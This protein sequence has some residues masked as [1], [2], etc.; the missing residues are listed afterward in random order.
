MPAWLSQF[1]AQ[2]QQFAPPGAGPTGWAAPQGPMYGYP[3]PPGPPGAGAGN[4][5]DES[6]LPE[7]L[8]QGANGG[9][10]APQPAMAQSPYGGYPGAGAPGAFPPGGNPGY[11]GPSG[12]M[13]ARS[14]IDDRALPGWMN[15]P[16]A[17]PGAPGHPGG[18]YGP[19]EGLDARSLIDES[20]LPQWLQ[21]GQPAAA[22]QAAQWNPATGVQEP[23]PAWL[24]QQQAQPAAAMFAPAPAP[25]MPP[26][27]GAQA[28]SAGQLPDESALP[29]WLRAQ[30]AGASGRSAPAAPMGQA[31][32]QPPNSEWLTDAHVPVR[33]AIDRAPGDAPPLGEAELPPWLRN[34]QQGNGSG[35]YPIPPQ[36]G[37]VPNEQ[38]PPWLHQGPGADPSGGSTGRHRALGG[39]PPGNRRD[40][41]GSRMR[42]PDPRWQRQQTGYGTGGYP[43]QPPP[44]QWDTGDQDDGY[45]PDG[46]EDW[47]EGQQPSGR[48]RGG[49]L[50]RFR[51][52]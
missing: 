46:Y 22:S 27:L 40:F 23:L 30:G 14:L 38:L 25:M 50:D 12:D 16:P 7:W 19:R 47:Q 48:R 21:G 5:L 24:A 44:G 8:R 51:R 26:S 35:A 33:P 41:T 31:P 15:Q 42:P 11:R 1:Q 18:A 39:Q 10:A 32:R 28:M 13:T 43:N 36:A 52:K 6:A 17:G 2:Q 49:F 29:D 4:L 45:P 37:G 20:S 9:Y 34:N 3:P